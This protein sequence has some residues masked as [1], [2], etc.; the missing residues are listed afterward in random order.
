MNKQRRKEL[1][2][3]VTMLYEAASR[4]NDLCEAEN[5]AYLNL[6]ENLQNSER[7]DIMQE[8]SQCFA[9]A[10]EDTERIIDDLAT[11]C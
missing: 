9:E 7:A 4:L 8:A 10:C 5:E 6:P 3:V 11:Y 2:E 1:Q